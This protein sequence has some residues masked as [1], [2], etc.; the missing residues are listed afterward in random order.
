MRRIDPVLLLFTAAVLA[1]TI[2]KGVVLAHPGNFL[3]FRDTFHRLVS[4]ADI[5]NPPAGEMTGFLYSPTFALLFA[6]FAMLPLGL[7]LLLWNGLNALSLYWGVTRVL[8]A[9]A[10]RLA[11]L[12]VFLDM[13]RSLQNSQTNALMAGLIVLA[14]AA[15]ERERVGSAAAAI[16]VGAFT[17]I[18]PAG[19]GVL[20]LMRPRPARFLGLFLALGLLFAALPL[21]V[22]SP[23][24]LIA[25][26]REWWSIIQRDG[27]LQGQS[28]M[29]F[30]SSMS[31]L[32]VP[33]LPLQ[34]A[35]TLLLLAPLIAQRLNWSDARFRLRWLC[36]LL[37]FS[38][39][40]NHQ[41]ES[42]S[43]VVA[44]TGVA[45]WYVTGPRSWWRTTLLALVLA[46]ETLPH[47]FFA[48]A[49]LYQH[50]I[51]P[52]ALDALP[53]LLVWLVMQYELWRWP[54]SSNEPKISPREAIANLA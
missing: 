3:M 24:A 54:R 20:G 32:S 2:Q 47:V 15:L 17:K 27:G 41:A 7:G 8:P 45:I 40:F 34:L 48:P 31:G 9:R 18:Y 10:A 42:P 5:Y 6:P 35:G 13:V 36:S 23:A 16:L 51:G 30:V 49:N 25:T 4:G 39:I 14:F 22:L 50:V 43:F 53:C 11:L 28:V 12:I 21:V 52:N 29:R 33:G 46:F 26:Y 37:V 44:S 19:A 1:V 38:V